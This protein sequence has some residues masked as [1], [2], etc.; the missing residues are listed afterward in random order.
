MTTSVEREV[1]T[2]HIT[3]TVLKLPLTG[4]ATRRDRTTPTKRGKT[5][6]ELG[7]TRPGRPGGGTRS[8]C[9]VVSRLEFAGADGRGKAFRR[10]MGSEIGGNSGIQ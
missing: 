4:E 9:V 3:V 6:Y 5:T 10:E 2:V 1:V 7:R 8:V